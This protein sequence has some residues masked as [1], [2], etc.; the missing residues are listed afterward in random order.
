MKYVGYTLAGIVAVLTVAVMSLLF[1]ANSSLD[2]S[3]RH[4]EETQQLP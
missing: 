3:F 1:S 4:T 2:N